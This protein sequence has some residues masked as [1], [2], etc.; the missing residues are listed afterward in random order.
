M[1]NGPSFFTEYQFEKLS[2]D[3][4][5]A[6]ENGYTVLVFFHEP[7]TTNIEEYKETKVL[8]DTDDPIKSVYDYYTGWHI[9]AAHKNDTPE[10]MKVYDLIT[11][12]ADVIKG[13]FAGH[14]HYNYYTE[15]KATDADGNDTVIPQYVM[16]SCGYNEY[17]CVTRIFV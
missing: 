10:T 12:S 1:D 14:R 8:D 5:T 2:A 3:L 17:G 15:I 16:R 6:R 7:L 13:I 9:G 4:K 11:S